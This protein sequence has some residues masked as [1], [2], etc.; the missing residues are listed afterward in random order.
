MK[1]I[2]T[3]NDVK[4]IEMLIPDKLMKVYNSKGLFTLVHASD[5]SLVYDNNIWFR[6]CISCYNFAYYYSKYYKLIREDGLFTLIRINDG[7]F[8]C[9]KDFWFKDIEY[10]NYDYIKIIRE[11]NLFNFIDKIWC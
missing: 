7:S 9:N 10:I 11:D 8:I 4:K 3:I 5:G 6:E 2:Q 1:P